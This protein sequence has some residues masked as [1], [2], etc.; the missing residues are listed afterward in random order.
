MI[1]AL[2]ALLLLAGAGCTQ[3]VYLGA[4]PDAGSCTGNDCADG[5]PEDEGDDPAEEQQ[6][7]ETE[8]EERQAFRSQ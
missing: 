5:T 4:L 8:H 7:D 6:Q 1:R 3:D 2:I